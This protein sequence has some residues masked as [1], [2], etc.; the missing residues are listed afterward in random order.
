M[1]PNAKI[2][3]EYSPDEGAYRK[4]DN[5]IDN[6]EVKQEDNNGLGMYTNNEINAIHKP[7][8]L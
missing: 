5:I 6:V 8:L 4:S 7:E 3:E 1:E 2:K